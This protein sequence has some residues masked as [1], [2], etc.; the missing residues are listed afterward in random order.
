M[1][2]AFDSNCEIDTL[3]V[4]HFETGGKWNVR[5]YVAPPLHGVRWFYISRQLVKAKIAK[6]THK[7]AAMLEWVKI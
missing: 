6:K 2:K 7:T 1:D 4:S 5:R 3:N